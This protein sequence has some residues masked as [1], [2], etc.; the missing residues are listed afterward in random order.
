ML[1]EF[2]AASRKASRSIIKQLYEL[3]G[4]GKQYVKTTK[5]AITEF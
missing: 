2:I 1:L 4:S 3:A 5:E